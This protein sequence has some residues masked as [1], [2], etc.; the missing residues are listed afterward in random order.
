MGGVSATLMPGRLEI[1]TLIGVLLTVL[2]VGVPIMRLNGESRLG[3]ELLVW[4]GYN[5]LSAVSRSNPDLSETEGDSQSKPPR[6]PSQ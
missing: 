5:S 3:Y 4:T 6:A 2:R 1:E